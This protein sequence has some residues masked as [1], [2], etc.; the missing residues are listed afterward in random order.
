VLGRTPL[1]TAIKA[2]RPDDGFV[3]AIE[4]CGAE[5]ARNVPP[6]ELKSNE[7]PDRIV[8]V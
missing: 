6:L 8:E 7:L 2:R 4:L 3:T 5:L 1:P